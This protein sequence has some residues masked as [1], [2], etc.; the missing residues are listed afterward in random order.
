[1]AVPDNATVN[2][3]INVGPAG[4][5]LDVDALVRLD[6][7]FDSDLDMFLLSPGGT[8]V[9]LSTDN[10]GGGNNFGTG[11]NDCSGTGTRF[12]DAAANPSPAGR[13][14]SPARSGRRA[15]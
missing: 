14:R 10:G 11:T 9:G 6:H 7:T 12:N 3:P 15:F 8:T 2:V 5:V 4:N 1:M 13:P